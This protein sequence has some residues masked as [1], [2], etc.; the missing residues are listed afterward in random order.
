MISAKELE[1]LAKL[2]EKGIITEK[3]FKAKKEEFLN[4][5]NT[6]PEEEEEI[7]EEEEVEEE[8]D[9]EATWV[10]VVKVIF[11]VVL[12]CSIFDINPIRWVS[13]IFDT[14]PCVLQIRKSFPHGYRNDYTKKICSNPQME[15]YALKG[16]VKNALGEW[17]P[18]GFLCS[19]DLKN[20]AAWVVQQDTY[21]SAFINA[22]A[23]LCN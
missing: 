11:A 19:V 12:V 6:Q 7:E 18:V 17:F 14:N 22:D 5:Y 10:T 3:E 9:S 4:Q 8:E 21:S 20:N 13:N 23:S 2:K 15:V 16:D 1:K